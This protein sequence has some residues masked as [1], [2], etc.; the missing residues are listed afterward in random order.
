MIH[1]KEGKMF[2]FLKNWVVSKLEPIEICW[3]DKND[4]NREIRSKKIDRCMVMKDVPMVMTYITRRLFDEQGRVSLEVGMCDGR[5][6]SID[7]HDY[8]NGHVVEY[9]YDSCDTKDRQLLFRSRL[10]LDEQGNLIRNEQ[11]NSEGVTGT[12]SKETPGNA[13]ISETHY[14]DEKEGFESHELSVYDEKGRLV[15]GQLKHATANATKVSYQTYIY[16]DDS[17]RPIREL[18]YEPYYDCLSDITRKYNSEGKQVKFL[19]VMT[20]PERV[21]SF[22]S[23]TVY[24]ADKSESV[25]LMTD[26]QD[27]NRIQYTRRN[28]DRTR[29]YTYNIPKRWHWLFKRI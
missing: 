14:T 24:S 27:G 22:G 8:S 28:A 1:D 11:I 21:C 18:F 3:Y 25:D 19:C 26:S 23:E 12:F 17:N 15:F 4:T 7:R 13:R 9:W 20:Y 2:K 10:Y 29:S 5:L 16:T 6:T